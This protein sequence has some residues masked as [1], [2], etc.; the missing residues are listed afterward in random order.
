MLTTKLLQEFREKFIE[1]DRD[2]FDMPSE[3]ISGDVKEVTQFLSDCIDKVEKQTAEQ[4]EKEMKP[5]ID[6]FAA[7]GQ[8]LINRG[9]RNSG[10]EVLENVGYIKGI[11]Y[12]LKSQ[13]GD[14]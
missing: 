7:A 12:K 1:E 5:A 2:C 3:Y 11:F 13:K 10:T 14:R 4:I 8:T 9:Y 6:D